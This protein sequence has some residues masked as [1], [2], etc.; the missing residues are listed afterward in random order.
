MFFVKILGFTIAQEP[1][2]RCHFRQF[3][4]RDRPTAPTAA[5]TAYRDH[6]ASE[7]TD[8]TPIFHI[9]LLVM[10][11][12]MFIIII[13]DGGCGQVPTACTAHATRKAGCNAGSDQGQPL[14]KV[15]LSAAF[16]R[17]LG[18]GLRIEIQDAT[19]V[20]LFER[21]DN[22]YMTFNFI[23]FSCLST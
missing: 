18:C 10:F 4:R 6:S 3:Q 22:N 17:G 5:P 2:C 19:H 8:A 21:A 15:F 20:F 13:E 14:C 16:L 11:G 1:L 12:I 9:H 7:R 23:D